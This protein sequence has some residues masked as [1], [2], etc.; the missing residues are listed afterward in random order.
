[1]AGRES[2]SAPTANGWRPPAGGLRLWAV[3]SWAEGPQIG[4]GAAFAF[5][6]DGKLLAVEPNM[7]P[8]V[9]SIRKPAGNTPGWKIPTSRSCG[10]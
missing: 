5:S 2:A 6:P 7:A 8:C 9:W 10:L 1:M 3:G 4:G